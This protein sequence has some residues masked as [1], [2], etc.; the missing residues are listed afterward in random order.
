MPTAGGSPCYVLRTTARFLWPTTQRDIQHNTAKL[1]IR[2]FALDGC[3]ISPRGGAVFGGVSGG[4]AREV[5]RWPRVAWL[6]VGPVLDVGR[7]LA[8]VLDCYLLIS[9]EISRLPDKPHYTEIRNPVSGYRALALESAIYRQKSVP[10]RV[11]GY[12]EYMEE[13][14]IVADIPPVLALIGVSRSSS[15]LYVS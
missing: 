14:H 9:R 4:G 11:F 6:S 13:F 10:R 8:P 12:L 3:A 5:F 1:A 15:L 2:P 7:R